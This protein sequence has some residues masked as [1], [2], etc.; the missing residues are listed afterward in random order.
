MADPEGF[1]LRWSRRKREA[2]PGRGAIEE[3]QLPDP[4]AEPADPPDAVPA[5]G[6][7]CADPPFD[8]A[9]LPPL[10]SIAARTD[11]KAFLAPGVP[12]A[13][14]QAALRR[15][16]S[17]DPTIRDFVGLSENAWDFNAPAGVPGFGPLQVSDALRRF[18]LGT[19]TG[20]EP[21]AAPTD[22]TAA[23]EDARQA[24]APAAESAT[25]DERL[26]EAAGPGEAGAGNEGGEGSTSEEKSTLKVDKR[27]AANIRVHGRA[28]PQ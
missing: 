9:A 13:L 5:E 12:A 3:R 15:A 27:N 26:V 21:R 1:L 2:E 16:W 7:V 4:Q 14:K 6:A 10:E 19:M 28:L 18:V 22:R 8:P 17:A 11:V 23:G 25:R 20:E 24:D